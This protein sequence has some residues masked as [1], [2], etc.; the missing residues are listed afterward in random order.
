MIKIS[1]YP[2]IYKSLLSQIFHSPI[3]VICSVL[4]FFPEY[5]GM[6]ASRRTILL[7]KNSIFGCSEYNSFKQVLLLAFLGFVLY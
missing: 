2:D 5:F 3:T 7:E 6:K 4:F 1:A